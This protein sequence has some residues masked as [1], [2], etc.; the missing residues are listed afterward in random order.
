MFDDSR[1]FVTRAF[2]RG[3]LDL[4]F[5][6]YGDQQDAALLARLRSWS[7]RLQLS[8][9]QAEGAFT[10]TFFVETWGY[11]EAGRVEPSLVTLIPKYRV[12]REGAGGGD[13]EADLALGW[14]RDNKLAI[15]QVLCEFKDIRSALDDPQNR[16]GSRR[17]P[18]EQCLNYVR[19]ARRGLIG[20]EP[21]Q[22]WWGLVTDMNEFRLYWWDRAPSQYLRFIIKR[23]NDLFAGDYDLLSD[24]EEARFDRFLFSKLFH[25]DQLLA[26]AGRPPLLRLVERQWVRDEKLED[27]FYGHYRA[28]RERLFNVLL[29]N[30]PAYTA[31]KTQLLRLSQRLLDRFI[32]A[33]YCEDMGER[34]TFPP[35]FIRDHLKSRSVEPFYDPNGQEL[36]TFFKRLFAEM[37]TG[38]QIGQVRVPHINGGLFA[39][40]AEIEAL[41]LPNHIF[42]AP[43]QGLNEASLESDK[44]TIFYLSA[45]YNYASGGS[46]RESLSLYTLGRIFEQSITELEYRAGELEGRESAASLSKRKRD[47][48]YYTPEKIVNY[49]VRQTLDAWFA[50]AK[51]ACGWPAQ[52]DEPPTK[53]QVEA[54]EARLKTLRLVDPACG[55]GAFLISAFR[56]LLDERI[57]VEREKDRFS[58]RATPG[59]VNEPAL[60]AE[61]LENNIYGVDINPAALEI[62]K[63][64]LW[65]HSSRADAPLSSLDHTMRCFNSLIGPDFWV[66]RPDDPS[67]RDRVNAVTTWREAFP[68]VWPQGRPGGFDIVLSNPPYVKLQNIRKLDPEVADWLQAER[69]DDTFQSARTG[70]FD[71]YLPFIEQG[72][73][74]LAPGGRMAYIA[75]SLWTVNEYGE[76][77]RRLIRQ[78]R[79]LDR[80]VDFKSYQVF[81]DVTTYTALQFF[82]RDPGE[83]IRIAAA[84][85]GDVEDIDWSDPALA[86]P[87]TDIPE[88]NE[89]PMVTG[90]ERALIARL[91]ATCMR[92]DDPRVTTAIF[93]GLITSADKIYHLERLGAGQYRCKPNGASPYV[94]EIED[95]I[96]KPLISGSEAKRYEDPETDIY[97][98]FPYFRDERGTMRL[99]SEEVMEQQFPKAWAYLKSWE[100]VLRARERGAFDDAT[101]WRFGRNQNL[102]K[103]DRIK[104]VVPR[105]VEHLKASLDGRGEVCLDNVDVGGI[106]PAENVDP[107]FLLGVL[108]G[109][110]ADFVF[111]RIAKPFRGGFRS[112]N[113]QFIAPLPVPRATREQQAEIAALARSLQH[114]WTRRRDLIKAA[115]DRL[116]VLSRARHREHW[117]WPDLPNLRDLQDSAPRTLADSGAR[118]AWAKEQLE[119]AVAE[120]LELLQAALDS[121]EP[122][123]AQFRDGELVL[124]AGGR[125]LLDR[126]YLDDAVGKLTASYWR[127]LL[128]SQNWPDASRLAEAL[129]QPP[130]E[131]QAPAARQFVDRVDAL[132]NQVADIAAQESAINEKLFT[133]YGLTEEERLLVEID[134]RGR[135]HPANRT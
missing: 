86:V 99:V 39:P 45:R 59:A 36:W 17:S 109:P 118:H 10:Q 12:P 13:G 52:D 102:D 48:V 11:G 34:M 51:A 26:E 5:R 40:D 46:V 64:A 100:T 121:G 69:G 73:R 132:L 65:L 7:E 19:G 43:G 49:L 122:L 3:Q 119:S 92:L 35:Q 84:P 130:S 41:S 111:Q 94:V 107:A 31:N 25:R 105:L 101:W 115:Q 38:G 128:A 125:H 54:Y 29:L 44:A 22:P 117:L 66:G 42:V 2:L 47:G 127:F 63:L 110:V 87:Y 133:L 56:R 75:P 76:G 53:A 23:P 124:H 93:Q 113:K 28:V 106:L 91:A 32:F 60:T 1:A 18:V 78:R 16:K 37:S 4:E 62:A 112:A 98:L 81:A 68:E 58:R 90:N 103:Q 9:T 67:L 61:I 135:K 8:E 129:R 126:I 30:N 6:A 116:S 14:F 96:M 114:G 85:E 108:N 95:E 134:Q 120:R 104:L 131:P 77:L 50:D 21:V 72:L 79:Q 74:L 88:D 80:W 33:F 24:T 70:N 15:P 97:V 57:A 123:Q 55:S 27:E 20:N 83:A 71:L 89:W 82:T